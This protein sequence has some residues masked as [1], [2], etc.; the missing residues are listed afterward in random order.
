MKEQEQ[1][2]NNGPV[3]LDL[4]TAEQLAEHA[5]AAQAAEDADTAGTAH[6]EAESAGDAA[7]AAETATPTSNTESGNN[8]PRK[9][10]KKKKKKKH[11]EQ[12]AKRQKS[13]LDQINDFIN[14]DEDQ[15]IHVNLHGLVGGEG[16]PGFFRKN[17]AFIAIIVIGTCAYVTCRYMMLGAV[18][19]HNKLSERLIDCRYKAL[20]LDSELLERTL[21]SHIEK[22]LKDSTIHAPREQSFPLPISSE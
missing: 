5:I 17:W 10:K 18:L 12:E 3:E 6:L 1:N 11:T 22:S 7:R 16:L 14:E 2:P 15:P 21:S 13:L 8:P 9:K 19:E 4:F 20:T